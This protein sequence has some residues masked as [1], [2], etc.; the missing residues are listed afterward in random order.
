MAN[1]GSTIKWLLPLL[2]AGTLAYTGTLD[3]KTGGSEPSEQRIALSRL[4]DGSNVLVTVLEENLEVLTRYGRL[5]VPVAEVQKI[6]FGLRIPDVEAKKIDEAIK[7]LSSSE[8]DQREEA[9]RNLVT[10]GVKA[11]PRLQSATKS[12]D[13]ELKERARIALGEI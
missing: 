6:E 1:F 13:A 3:E 12:S 4:R 9:A 11:I 10:Y 2:G 5:K 8:F 7:L